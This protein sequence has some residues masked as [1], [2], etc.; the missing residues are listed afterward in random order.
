MASTGRMYQKNETSRPRLVVL[1]ISSTEVV[2]PSIT[3]LSP[4]GSPVGAL[5]VFCA[6]NRL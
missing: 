6:Q 3:R 5:P 1:I 4:A 2:P